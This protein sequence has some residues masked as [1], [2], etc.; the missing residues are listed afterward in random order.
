MIGSSSS[1][2]VFRFAEC[3]PESTTKTACAVQGVP[4][5]FGL[6]V[7]VTSLAFPVR[8][9]L[10]PEWYDRSDSILSVGK[11]TS[12]SQWPIAALMQNV[13]SQQVYHAIRLIFPIC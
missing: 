1:A 8:H 9:G 13:E 6:I 12:L 7:A 11:R 4:A 5:S 2:R 10:T 3:R